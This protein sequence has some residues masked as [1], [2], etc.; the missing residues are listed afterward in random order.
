M[1]YRNIDNICI[2]HAHIL[3]RNFSGEEGRYNAAGKRNFCV[4]IED[5]E[6]AEKL[7]ADGWN[8][9]TLPARDPDGED[10][11]YI[12]VAV[13]FDYVPPKVMLVTSH[14]KR[15]L[16]ED[17][18]GM[19]D[20]ADIS[21]V[22]VVIRPYQWEVNGNEGVKAYLKAIYVTI[23]EDEFADKYADDPVSEEVPF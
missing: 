7:L 4:V 8:V 20:H 13:S 12:Q 17:T 2:E 10:L 1:K 19:L 5:Q 9:K 21:N 23:D 22:D 3:F 15:M 6:Y 18:V 16:D 14:G 11:L